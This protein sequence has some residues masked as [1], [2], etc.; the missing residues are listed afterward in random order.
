MS[1]LTSAI[2][3][4]LAADYR[5]ALRY[6]Q[7]LATQG[8]LLDRIGIFQAIARCNEKLGH[9]KRAAYWHERAG[10]G[11]LRVPTRVMGAQERAHYALVEYRG[12]LQDYMSG[13]AM[14]RAAQRYLNALNMC[15]KAGKEG[16]SHEM[17][18]AGHLSAKLGFLKKAAEFFM[19]SAE[20]FEQ[21]AKLKLAREMYE[22]AA[23]CFQKVGERKTTKRVRV[24]AAR[25]H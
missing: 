6:Y 2:K 24:T 21:E 19:D 12:A 9:L 17:L 22:L 20:Q 1:F 23:L 4:E 10:D 18:F 8:S 7:R 5:K 25:L 16:Y 13:A 3:A 14:R 15:L 11:Y